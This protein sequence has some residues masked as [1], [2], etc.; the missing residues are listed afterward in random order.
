M[1]N[2]KIL[3]FYLLTLVVTGVV[4]V[5]STV[6]VESNSPNQSAIDDENV[7]F[8]TVG[9]QLSVTISLVLLSLFFYQGF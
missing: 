3:W 9:V 4:A 8:V 5:G 7:A 1:K 2:H 6:I